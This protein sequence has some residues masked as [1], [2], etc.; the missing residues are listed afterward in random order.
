MKNLG[1]LLLSVLLIVVLFTLGGTAFNN[2]LSA[3]GRPA[4]II[5][6]DAAESLSRNVLKAFSENFSK[7]FS[8]NHFLSD[9]FSPQGISEAQVADLMKYFKDV[10]DSEFRIRMAATCVENLHWYERLPIWFDMAKS[11]CRA[12]AAAAVP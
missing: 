7:N 6:P 10:K 3:F 2:L 8:G 11:D 5:T 4:P 1:S 9:N 12:Q